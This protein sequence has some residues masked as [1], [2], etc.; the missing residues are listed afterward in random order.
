MKREA[1]VIAVVLLALAGAALLVIWLHDDEILD[2]QVV[3]AL[4]GPQAPSA[5]PAV[6]PQ[7]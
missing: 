3:E 4:A 7:K 5:P 6:V 1:M 2:R